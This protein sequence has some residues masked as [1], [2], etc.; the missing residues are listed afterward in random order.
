VVFTPHP[1][2][3]EGAGTLQKLR[4]IQSLAQKIA[5]AACLLIKPFSSPVFPVAHPSGIG[6]AGSRKRPR[7]ARTIDRP[8]V[9]Q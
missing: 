3:I 5:I 8:R 6:L 2:L 7:P 9:L 4:N 1:G